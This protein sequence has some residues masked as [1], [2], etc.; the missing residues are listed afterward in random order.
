MALA[1]R[2][3]QQAEG[4]GQ[5]AACG[6]GGSVPPR[7]GT[8]MAGLLGTRL[9]VGEGLAE[10]PLQQV[11]VRVAEQ[12]GAG[13][14]IQGDGADPLPQRGLDP[15]DPIDQALPPALRIPEGGWVGPLSSSTR[16]P[17]AS[18]TARRSPLLPR[19][20]RGPSVPRRRKPRPDQAAPLPAGTWAVAACRRLS[21]IAVT[22]SQGSCRS[23]RP[24]WP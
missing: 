4:P 14:A 24:K 12:K 16:W 11:A 6:G 20:T 21:A 18:T 2:L 19:S 13:G 5:A 9:V 10:L 15:L 8:G 23:L 22:S 3:L 17:W 7:Q 1:A